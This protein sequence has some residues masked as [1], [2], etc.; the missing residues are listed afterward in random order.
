MNIP[1]IYQY[2][3]DFIEIINWCPTLFPICGQCNECNQYIE[4][5]RYFNS[6]NNT[7]IKEINQQNKS[8]NAQDHLNSY[9][10]QL[11]NK[12]KTIM[13]YRK[14]LDQQDKKLEHLTIY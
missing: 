8:K 9:K 7:Q 2:L 13:N 6:Q 10:L 12:D 3:V 11:F 4:C 1:I 14:Q 5:K